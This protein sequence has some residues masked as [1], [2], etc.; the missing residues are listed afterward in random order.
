MRS[1]RLHDGFWRAGGNDQP[2]VGPGFRPEINEVIGA[3]DDFQVV[4]DDNERVPLLH[5]PVEH[6]QQH[7]DVVEV[8]AGG[9][10]VEDEQ[11]AL[12]PIAGFPGQ[13]ADEFEPLRF[14]AAQDV[15]RLAEP[16]IAKPHLGKQP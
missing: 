3:L 14:A 2:A 11:R 8:Q 1:A 13:M 6:A 4:L 7:R 12:R 15:E 9:R 10:L 5:Q 16:Q